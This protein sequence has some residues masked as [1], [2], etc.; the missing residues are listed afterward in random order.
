MT[1]ADI[2]MVIVAIGSIAVVTGATPTATIT[3]HPSSNS[4]FDNNKKPPPQG[5]AAFCQRQVFPTL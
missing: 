1:V 4:S 2:G 3:L 5:A